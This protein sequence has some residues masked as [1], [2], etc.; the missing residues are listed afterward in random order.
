MIEQQMTLDEIGL[1]PEQNLRELSK[2]E[3]KH[4]T[5]LR[6]KMGLDDLCGCEWCQE[7]FAE[8]AHWFKGKGQ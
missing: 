8:N 6:H 4:A 7:V 1:P 5:M 3:H 2:A